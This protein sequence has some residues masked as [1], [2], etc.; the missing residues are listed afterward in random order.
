MSSHSSFE[1]DLQAE[2]SASTTLEVPDLQTFPSDSTQPLNVEKASIIVVELTTLKL[3]HTKFRGKPPNARLTIS[4]SGTPSLYQTQTASRNSNPTWNESIT[5]TLPNDSSVLHFEVAH[6]SNL[7][8]YEYVLGEANLDV[9][10]IRKTEEKFEL[11]LQPADV[12]GYELTGCGSLIISACQSN[13]RRLSAG[14]LQRTLSFAPEMRRSP[15]TSSL[16]KKLPVDCRPDSDGFKAYIKLLGQ[17]ETLCSITEDVTEFYP[18]V[19]LTWTIASGIYAQSLYKHVEAD[20]KVAEL[21]KEIAGVYHFVDEYQTQPSMYMTLQH[22][23]KR[24]LKQTI[25]CVLFLQEYFEIGFNEKDLRS[26]SENLRRLKTY[27]ETFKTLHRVLRKGVNPLHR[28]SASFGSPDDIKAYIRDG[29][30]SRLNP[31]EMDAAHRACCSPRVGLAI[32]EDISRWV[33]SPYENSNIFWLHGGPRIGKSMIATTAAQFFRD[34]SRLGAFVFFDSESAARSNPTML[35]RTIAAQISAVRPNV[36]ESVAT[37]V[38]EMPAIGQSPLTLQFDELL[39][40]PLLQESLDSGYTFINDLTFVSRKTA[41]AVKDL[42][43]KL[44]KRD[45]DM[46]DMYIYNDFFDYAQLDLVDKQLSAIHSKIVKR[47]YTEAFYLLETLSVFQ[48]LAGLSYPMA[49]DG[50]RIELT[51]KVYGASLVTVLRALKKEDRLDLQH[52]PSLE[53]FLM[54]G[55]SWGISM[56]GVDMGE[57]YKVLNGIGQRLCNAQDKTPESIALRKAQVEE[58]ILTLPKKEQDDYKEMCKKGKDGMDEDDEEDD[59][60]EWY[61]RQGADEDY[62]SSDFTLSRVWKEYKAYLQESPTKPLRGPPEWDLSKWSA[63]Q[64]AQFSFNGMN[65]DD[66]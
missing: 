20:H 53:T 37:V 55:S 45:P 26:R 64:R 54:A 14:F 31:V 16:L 12:P 59:G 24:I 28:P 18:L 6:N 58:W 27:I 40:K 35:F 5:I 41:D 32:L 13:V 51:D 11:P 36:A 21:L 4:S 57:Y 39:V 48:D 25:N 62:K 34:T 63:A 29:Y 33:C 22:T 10:S 50:E 30:I 42:L 3:P 7:P 38:K 61:E 2:P 1:S 9:R 43:S 60:K 56:T 15:R 66:Y 49:D 47:D 17:L 23:M 65:E 19:P 8:G 44:D 46:F 52:F